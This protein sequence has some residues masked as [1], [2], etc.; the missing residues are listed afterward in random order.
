MRKGTGDEGGGGDRGARAGG[1]DGEKER[2]GKEK[3]EEGKGLR[4]FLQFSPLLSPFL[5]FWLELGLL[6][7]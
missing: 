7:T 5:G 3:E 6:R 2:G 1:K 4:G